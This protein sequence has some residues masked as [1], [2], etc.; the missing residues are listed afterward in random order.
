MTR[1]YC[2]NVPETIANLI[3][4]VYAY[5]FFEYDRKYGKVI[6]WVCDDNSLSQ[7]EEIYYWNVDLFIKFIWEG[8]DHWT[9][10]RILDWLDFIPSHR[11]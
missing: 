5:S 4:S 7:I 8:S 2:D 9:H 3:N 6:S 11:A 1:R 10:E